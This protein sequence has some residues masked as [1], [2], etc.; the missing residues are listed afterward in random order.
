MSSTTSTQVDLGPTLG[1][2][3]IGVVLGAVYVFV[4]VRVTRDDDETD[5]LARRSDSSESPSCKPHL[6]CVRCND[7]IFSE[8]FF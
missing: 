2:L 1:A 5:P 8:L 3:L 7:A 4:S 6:M